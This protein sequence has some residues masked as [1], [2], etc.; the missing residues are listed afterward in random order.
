[1]PL[2]ISAAR[3]LKH[4]RA[5]T[6]EVYCRDD[7]LWDIDACLADTKTHDIK[8]THGMLPAGKPIHELWLRL[9]VDR[10]ADVIDA[11]AVSDAVPFC[12]YCDTIGPAYRKL[13]GLNLLKGFRQGIRDRLSG[14]EGCTHLNE[15]ANILPTAAIQALSFSDTPRK[16][17]QGSG[18][19]AQKPFE[20]DNCH[21]LQ[22]DGPAV[23]LYYPQWS[24][25]TEK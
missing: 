19:P 6:I 25:R 18:K 8:L 4:K 17:G 5:V 14:I 20:L 7:G 16:S 15:L 13:V 24:T 1:M 2:P 22:S 9:T 10:N 3:T 23:A 21:A 12:G 11:F